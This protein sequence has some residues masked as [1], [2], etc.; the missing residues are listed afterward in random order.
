M[1]RPLLKRAKWNK[2][3]GIHL[4]LLNKTAINCQHITKIQ[5]MDTGISACLGRGQQCLLLHWQQ[6]SCLSFHLLPNSRDRKWFSLDRWCILFDLWLRKGILALQ[7]PSFTNAHTGHYTPGSCFAVLSFVSFI[8]THVGAGEPSLRVIARITWQHSIKCLVRSKHS[9]TCFM[10]HVMLLV[11]S[12]S[13][14][15]IQ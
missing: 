6:H 10:G 3:V 12:W 4:F 13:L 2:N 9:A 1:A 8:C 11:L 5:R 14:I 15:Q 7:N